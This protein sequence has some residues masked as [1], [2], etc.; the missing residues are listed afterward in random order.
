MSGL[1]Y[2]N[3]DFALKVDCNVNLLAFSVLPPHCAFV[4]TVY[5]IN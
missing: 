3:S 4:A 2:Y 5:T 1:K